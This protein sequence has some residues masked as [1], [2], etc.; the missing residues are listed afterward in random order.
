MSRDTRKGK[1]FR[2]AT[3]ADAWLR[4]KGACEK[5]GLVLKPGGFAYDHVI[6]VAMGGDATLR[7]CEV[8]CDGCHGEKTGKG[9]VPQIAKAKRQQAAHIDTK[10]KSRRP[11]PG[12]KD[13]GVKLKIGGGTEPR[14]TSKLLP[15]RPLPPRKSGLYR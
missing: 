7:N 8:L 15:S 1:E 5:C 13:S 6:P 2:K 4:C 12:G 11:L 9:D 14:G 3:K 10:T